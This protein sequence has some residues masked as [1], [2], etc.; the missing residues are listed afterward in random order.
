M[1]SVLDL[2]GI[3][4][5]L[6]TWVGL[7]LGAI[8]LSIVFIIRASRAHW[9]ETDA[10][11]VEGAGSIQLRWMTIDGQLMIRELDSYERDAISDP[12]SLTIHYNR[13][14]PSRARFEVVGHGEKVLWI[15]GLILF[16][17][18]I[19]AAIVG[20]IVLFVSR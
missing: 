14:S 12:D 19:V 13:R 17:L 15:I 3:L 1:S 6:F 11:I 5:E 20:L 10:V 7:V 2:V 8:C 18:G 4:A 9:I 16:G